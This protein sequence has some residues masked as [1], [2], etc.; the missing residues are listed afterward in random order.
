MK[1]MF[2][3]YFLHLPNQLHFKCAIAP[4]L[5]EHRDYYSLFQWVGYLDGLQKFLE[6]EFVNTAVEENWIITEMT[7]IY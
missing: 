7:F 2:F 5:S 6:K 1:V 3:H 4:I